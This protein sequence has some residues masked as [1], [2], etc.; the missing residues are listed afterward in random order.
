MLRGVPK[1][2]E[3][4]RARNEAHRKG[5]RAKTWMCGIA[6]FTHIAKPFS[7]SRIQEATRTLRHR[8]PDQQGVWESTSASLGAR[9]LRVIDHA[10]GDQPML[11]ADR[12]VVVV[13]NGE[14]FNFREV[15]SELESLGHRFQ[16]DCDT[17]V[18][19]EG[20]LRWNIGCFSRLRGM[21]AVALWTESKRQ[22]VL[23]RDRLGIKPLYYSTHRGELYFGSELKA[24]FCHPEIK[25]SI[26][27]SCLTAFCALSYVPG[28]RTMIAG[29]E[30]VP[31][32]SVVTWEA[33]KLK[34]DSYWRID[35]RA[36]FAGSSHEATEELDSLITGS[37]AEQLN[38]EVDVGLWLSG[39]MDSSTLLHYATSTKTTPLKTF[40]ITFNGRE[41]DESSQIAALV[42]QYGAE[43]FQLDLHPEIAIAE[44]V[45]ELVYYAD[46]PNADAGALPVW[47]LSRMAAQHVTVALSGEGADELFG[48]YITYRADI[49]AQKLAAMPEWLRRAALRLSRYVPASNRK[50]G[51][52]YKL[53]RFLEGLSLDS[54][55]A[56]LFWN[57]TSSLQSRAEL[58]Q[59]SDETIMRRLVNEMPQQGL[60]RRFLDF[61][62]Q[63]FLPDN[64]LSKVDR[65]SMAHALEVRPPFLDHRIVEFAAAL[66]TDLL[67][68]GRVHKRVLRHLMRDR[69]PKTVTSNRKTGFDIPV[70][71]WLRN[72]LRT[73]LMDTLTERTVRESGL[74]RWPSIEGMLDAH[75]KRRT[76]YGYHLWALLML[77][78]W[79]DRWKIETGH[80]FEAASQLSA[81]TV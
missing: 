73:L 49:Y 61:D 19:L 24:L 66:P 75:M 78:Q 28:P 11:S 6:G 8:G 9:R 69:L 71:D 63:Y 45:M 21:F 4:L 58:L 50:I 81:V 53:Q 34:T 60:V 80:D 52:E 65:M 47:F 17:E 26:D 7:R 18:V 22:L 59:H 20:F 38:A 41:F 70:H 57:G 42:R 48:G 13:F 79:I 54:R 15:R 72:H 29:I 16:T 10:R 27:P 68:Q 74:F 14:I 25:R 51:F 36:T 64:L 31:Q 46:E 76:N 37:V 44:A 23:A 32:G 56:H 33:G 3:T 40:S 12:D 77:F 55:A 35:E 62:R 5:R 30:R 67:I 39:G 1:L 43:H 2:K